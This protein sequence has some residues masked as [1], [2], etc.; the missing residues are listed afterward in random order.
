MVG[1]TTELTRLGVVWVS[2][3]VQYFTVNAFTQRLAY[4][5]VDLKLK[6]EMG[7]G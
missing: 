3:Q 5:I 7:S 2:F 4:R 6:I 1:S